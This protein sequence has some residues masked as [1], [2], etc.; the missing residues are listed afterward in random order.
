MS[1][2]SGISNGLQ[3][4]HL[5][6]PGMG[7]SLFQ[8]RFEYTQDA[9]GICTDVRPGHAC[10]VAVDNVVVRNF[11]ATAQL[12]VNLTLA[13]TLARDP[14]TNEI[15]ASITVN[16]IGSAVA[17][18]VIPTNARLGSSSALNP[19]AVLGDIAPGASATAVFRF[20]ASAGASGS[21]GILRFNVTYDGGSAGGSFRMILP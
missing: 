7:G 8:L 15:I 10:G 2:W 11:I 20:P 14:S 17:R 19:F 9:I 12:S 18:N 5:E 16:N 4:V 1:A 6:L 13:P 3:H 21:P